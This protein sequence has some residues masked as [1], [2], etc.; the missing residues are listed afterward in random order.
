[1]RISNISLILQGPPIQS[2][3]LTFQQQEIFKF[4]PKVWLIFLDG[5]IFPFATNNLIVLLQIMT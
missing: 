2:V 1:M 5:L 4:R 3:F